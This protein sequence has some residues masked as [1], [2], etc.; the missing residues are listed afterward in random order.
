MAY[1]LSF[2]FH[3]AGQPFTANP[4]KGYQKKSPLQSEGGKNASAL[5]FSSVYHSSGHPQTRVQPSKAGMDYIQ[6]YFLPSFTYKLDII[7]RTQTEP[8]QVGCLE[9]CMP[10]R[11]GCSPLES[12]GG[13]P[14]S[15][16]ETSLNRAGSVFTAPL[17]LLLMT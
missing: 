4:L 13:C 2:E 6:D 5:R 11:I 14:H 8:T 12:E 7:T 16:P 3:S 1:L 10:Q 15:P 9:G 17:L